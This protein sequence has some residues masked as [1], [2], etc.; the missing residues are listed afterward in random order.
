MIIAAAA[1]LAGRLAG[2]GVRPGAGVAETAQTL[3]PPE[4]PP[5]ERRLL[6]QLARQVVETMLGLAGKGLSLSQVQEA[7]QRAAQKLI[8]SRPELPRSLAARLTGEVPRLLNLEHLVDLAGRGLELPPLAAA[9]EPELVPGTSAAFAQV[10]R[11]LEQVAATD[12]PVLLLG[13]TGTGKEL[14]ARRLH[15]L[16]PR[17]SGPLVAVNCA[18]LPQSLLESELFGH[19]KGAFTGASQ[20]HAGLVRAAA[21]GTLFLDEIGQAGPQVQARLLRVLEQRV[22]TPVGGSREI[23]VDFRL[24]AASHR[25]LARAA[26]Q[27]S[28]SRALLYRLQVVPIFLPPLRERRED[29]GPLLEHLLTQA[30]LLA[31]KTRGLAPQT[32]QALVDYDWPGNVRELS[33]VI[34]RLVVLAP[35]YEIGPQALPPEIA[36]GGQQGRKR[37]TQA[38]TGLDG[39][40]AKR[41]EGLAALLA[42]RQG[43]ELANQDLRQA[44]GCSDST[45]KNILRALAAAGLVQAAGSRGG[46]RYRV[47]AP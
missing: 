46:R 31:K 44:L 2:G 36:G 6:E 17:K 47:A 7:V 27:G 41:V 18:A 15:R 35:E 13:E 14:L 22:V 43:Q 34:Q 23:P 1:D 21:G 10:L 19:E 42:A 29:I 20:A 28:F 30:C 40:P 9:A 24:V 8:T 38:L 33:H 4:V 11:D 45:A 25:D 5:E 12:F 37:F 16:S 39:V 3:S 32:R 26:A